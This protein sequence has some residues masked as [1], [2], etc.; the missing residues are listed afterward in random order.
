[1]THIAIVYDSVRSLAATRSSPL[2]P[3]SR[4]RMKRLL[5]DDPEGRSFFSL[6][7]TAD[8]WPQA[9]INTQTTRDAVWELLTERL[10]PAQKQLL[11]KAAATHWRAPANEQPS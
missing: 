3:A 6:I 9:A 5:R 7:W 8:R 1:M 10:W 11:G 2:T 4:G